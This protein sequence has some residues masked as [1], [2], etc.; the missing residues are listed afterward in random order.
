MNSLCAPN[1]FQI[2]IGK[3]EIFN[4]LFKKKKEKSEIKIER[5]KTEHIKTSRKTNMQQANTYA[6][7]EK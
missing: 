1:K 7:K 3:A 2:K 5:E 6:R 4:W